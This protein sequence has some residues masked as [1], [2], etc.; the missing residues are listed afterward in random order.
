MSLRLVALQHG[1][2]TA[3]HIESR[4]RLIPND[5]IVALRIMMHQCKEN[6]FFLHYGDACINCIV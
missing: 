6:I 3:N 2:G 4:P 1:V 5:V